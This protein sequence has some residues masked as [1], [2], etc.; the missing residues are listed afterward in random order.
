[1]KSTTH[2]F[3]KGTLT[4][5]M[6]TVKKVGKTIWH[7]DFVAYYPNGRQAMTGSYVH[8]K[9]HGTWQRWYENGTLASVH[10]YGLGTLDGVYTQFYENGDKA[11]EGV[12]NQGAFEGEHRIYFKGGKLRKAFKYKAGQILRVER[13]IGGRWTIT[14]LEKNIWSIDDHDYRYKKVCELSDNGELVCKTPAQIMEDLSTIVDPEI[15]QGGPR[16]QDTGMTM[17]KIH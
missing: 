15:V 12:F 16:C 2:T 9:P 3:K 4:V 8:G 1:M 5:Q 14:D 6:E 10:H 17:F 7:G 13:L 11:R